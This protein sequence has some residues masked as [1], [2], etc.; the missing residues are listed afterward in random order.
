RMTCAGRY[1]PGMDLELL[2]SVAKPWAYWIAPMIL[3]ASVLGVLG[4]ILNYV[5]KVVAAKYPKT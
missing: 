1:D 2:F 3:V 4:V 5:F